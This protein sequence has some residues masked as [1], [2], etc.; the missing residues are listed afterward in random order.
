[1]LPWRVLDSVDTPEGP[2][3]IRQRGERDFLM[4]IGGRVLMTSAAHRS[5]DALAELTCGLPGAG[6]RP[7]ILLGG[8]GMG[9]TL[10]AALDRLPAQARVDVVDLNPAVVGWCKGVLGRLTKNAAA[11]RRV[12][13]QVANVATVIAQAPA[14]AY[15]AILLDLYEGPHEAVNRASD[16]LYGGKALLRAWRALRKGGVFGIWSEEPDAAFAKRLAAA[17][18]QTTAHSRARGGRTHTV[19]V[20]TKIENNA[21]ARAKTSRS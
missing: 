10:R 20:G 9:Y 13:I 16:P 2:L 17:G 4:T 19:Y 8:L 11:D 5:E 15:D 12:R 21:P 1:V 14:D 3:Q 18:F 6:K 7:Q